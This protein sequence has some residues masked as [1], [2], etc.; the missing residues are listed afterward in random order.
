[1]GLLRCEADELERREIIILRAERESLDCQRQNSSR[2]CRSQRCPSSEAREIAV[3]VEDMANDSCVKS[4]LTLLKIETTA[5]LNKSNSRNS[6]RYA[7]RPRQ[8]SHIHTRHQHLSVPTRIHERDGANETKE[9]GDTG[10]LVSINKSFIILPTPPTSRS[11]L[12]QPTLV[13][14]LRV[15]LQKLRPLHHKTVH[16]AIN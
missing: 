8:Q 14:S 10:A 16:D 5:Y 13:H 3:E 7:N 12:N 15:L 11:P 2:C 4:Q 6:A 9:Q 1:V